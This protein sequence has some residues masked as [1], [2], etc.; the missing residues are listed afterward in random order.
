MFFLLYLQHSNPLRLFGGLF[1]KRDLSGFRIHG[2]HNGQG[3]Q[4]VAQIPD[5]LTA[6]LEA[7]LND[8]AQTLNSSTCRFDNRNQ[9]LH[10]ASVCKKIVNN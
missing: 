6:N 9:A 10:S 1:P 5:H 4:L 3:F 8:D 2:I 7:F